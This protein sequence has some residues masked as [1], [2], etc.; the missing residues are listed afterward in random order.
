MIFVDRSGRWDHSGSFANDKMISK[1]WSSSVSSLLVPTREEYMM[2]SCLAWP[3]MSVLYF[4]NVG[5][6]SGPCKEIFGKKKLK[7]KVDHLN[8]KSKNTLGLC[9]SFLFHRD[10]TLSLLNGQKR[11]VIG[12]FLPFGQ[13]IRRRTSLMFLASLAMFWSAT[14]YVTKQQ[15]RHGSI[16][17]R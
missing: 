13:N 2:R 10:H 7:I 6:S 1:N 5:F 14:S 8:T 15:H 11:Q 17:V 9:Q 12:C 16:F 3:G 4:R